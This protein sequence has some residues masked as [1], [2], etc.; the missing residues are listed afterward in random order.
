MPKTFTKAKIMFIYRNP[1]PILSSIIDT[2]VITLAD[3]YLSLSDRVIKI[4]HE[5]LVT[6]SKETVERICSYLD[7]DY[8]ERTLEKFHQ[9]E[10]DGRMGDPTGTT[11]HQQV[12]KQSMNK[13]KAVLH[14]KVR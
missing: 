13:W 12:E 3:G 7:L 14:T 10:L 9:Q 6:N 8:D 5:E 1:A 11:K 4:N 2:W